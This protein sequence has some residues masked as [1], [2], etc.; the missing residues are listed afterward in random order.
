MPALA[1]DYPLPLGPADP[2]P[3]SQVA[4]SGHHFFSTNTTPV[5]E[6]NSGVGPGNVHLGVVVG[7]KGAN[8]TAP[9]GS[10]LGP[11]GKGFG[12]VPWLQL[13]TTEESVNTQGKTWQKI[14]RLNTAGG[15]PPKTCEGR[16]AGEVFSI[17]YA[18]NYWYYETN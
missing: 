15:S 18:A 2:Q 10:P 12:T 9:A 3:V 14:Y 6:L 11:N 7:K 4:I 1:L 13:G 16:R 17:E 8:S 5:F